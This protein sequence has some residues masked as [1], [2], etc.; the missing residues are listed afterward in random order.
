MYCAIYARNVMTNNTYCYGDDPKTSL[1]MHHLVVKWLYINR[2]AV[3]EVVA[4]RLESEPEED[5]LECF[6]EE[7][8][9]L[10]APP[11]HVHE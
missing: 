10:Y 4:I 3:V 2:D 7:D 1:Y 11:E 8:D 6:V 5:I 9:L